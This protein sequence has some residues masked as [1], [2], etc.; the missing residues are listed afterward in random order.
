MT[1][2]VRVTLEARGIGVGK[3]RVCST[4]PATLV[5][6][7]YGGLT[8]SASLLRPTTT[9]VRS[10]RPF[11]F[12]GQ[13]PLPDHG[14]ELSV[15]RASDYSFDISIARSNTVV[16][17]G[18]G[19]IDRDEPSAI[20]IA[21]WTDETI[22]YGVV[23]YSIRDERTIVGYYI[24]KMTPDVPGEDIA[25]GRTAGGFEGR[26]V[27]NSREV[28]GRTWGPHEWDLTKRGEVTDLTWREHGR[29]FCRGIGMTDPG[30]P[31]SIIATYIAL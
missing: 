11:G 7:H 13:F 21:W 9:Q 1:E 4:D 29:I 27:L 2:D 22:P 24:S 25:I 31:S 28:N 14:L 20:L 30:D 6:T 3:A 18:L 26:F 16:A 15:T 23:K 17:R 12:P 8:Q 10:T 19:L 5:V